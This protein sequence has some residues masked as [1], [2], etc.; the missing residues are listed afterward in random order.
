MQAN[1]TAQEFAGKL[2]GIY[3][4]GVLTKLI[5][6]GYQTGLFE[7]GFFETALAIGVH[8]CSDF[9]HAF[10]RAGLVPFAAWCS[11]D[12]E[13]TH[14]LIAALDRDPTRKSY[15]IGKAE[16]RRTS[17]CRIFADGLGIG[18]CP[19]ETEDRPHC[20]H[21]IGFTECG[22]FGVDGAVVTLEMHLNDAGSIHH[23]RR[24]RPSL[25]LTGFDRR[26]CRFH[27]KVKGQRI[28]RLRDLRG[29]GGRKG[30]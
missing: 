21:G 15:N 3:T 24:D 9:G 19:V 2:L 29:R 14:D 16:K 23:K 13:S 26:G 11:A 17:A 27:G 12:A 30:D 20:H 7:V 6:I 8:P 28:S 10:L 5:D 1:L 22:V 18:A 4:G 25:G